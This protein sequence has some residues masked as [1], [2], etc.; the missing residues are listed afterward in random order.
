M[1]KTIEDAEDNNNT[2]NNS[3]SEEPELNGNINPDL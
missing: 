2:L 3:T 1:N